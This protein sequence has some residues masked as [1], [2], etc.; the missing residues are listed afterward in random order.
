[1]LKKV[2]NKEY[3]AGFNR[4]IAM[5]SASTEFELE[6]EPLSMKTKLLC[7]AAY[8]TAAASLAFA[9]ATSN[10]PPTRTSN[11]VCD[12]VPKDSFCIATPYASAGVRG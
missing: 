9:I 11:N 2:M 8:I 4:R 12:N 1:M 10:T 7:G 3:T 6:L 5:M